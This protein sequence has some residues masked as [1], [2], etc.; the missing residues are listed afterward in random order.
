[1]SE[2]RNHLG[3]TLSECTARL[4]H[5]KVSARVAEQYALAVVMK[6]E[7]T[8]RPDKNELIVFYRTVARLITIDKGY[9]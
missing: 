2:P 4:I 8:N 1:M 9:A 6:L 3:E 7:W 5:D